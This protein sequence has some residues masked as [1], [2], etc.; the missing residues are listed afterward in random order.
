MVQATKVGMWWPWN[1]MKWFNLDLWV[2][3]M[4]WIFEINYLSHGVLEKNQQC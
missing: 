4:I 3:K 2:Q 1:E